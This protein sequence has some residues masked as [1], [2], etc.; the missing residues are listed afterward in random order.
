MQRIAEVVLLSLTVVGSCTEAFA[1]RRFDGNDAGVT[2]P[3]QI[4]ID[5]GPAQ[6]LRERSTGS[7]PDSEIVLAP[8]ESARGRPRHD[9]LIVAADC[10]I[11]E[12]RT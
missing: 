8:Y 12:G 4:E 10:R 1:F 11:A 3:G 7:V 2:E 9:Q 6:Y 5:L